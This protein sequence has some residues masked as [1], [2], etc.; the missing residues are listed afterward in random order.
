ME[1]ERKRM[2]EKAKA[3]IARRE[4][5]K[6]AEEAARKKREEEVRK[7]IEKNNPNSPKD[8]IFYAHRKFIE[9]SRKKGLPG[10]PKGVIRQGEFGYE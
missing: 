4:A 6:R 3:E 10:N 9:P 1:L 7:R 2:E 8:D 5:R